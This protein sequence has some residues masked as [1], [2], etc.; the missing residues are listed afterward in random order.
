MLLFALVFV[1]IRGVFVGSAMM[2]DLSVGGAVAFG[3]FVS[4]TM[5]S[6]AL[7]E[8]S[9]G[10]GDLRRN[11][12]VVHECWFFEKLTEHRSRRIVNEDVYDSCGCVWV[13]SRLGSPSGAVIKI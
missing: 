4:M 11:A 3:D 2:A 9:W 7:D 1:L 5:A 10:N 12:L 8:R 6:R 13:V